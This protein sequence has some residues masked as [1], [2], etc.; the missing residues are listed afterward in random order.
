MTRD[1]SPTIE[2]RYGRAI[3][4]SHL[5][6]R[7]SAG[8]VDKLIAAGWIKD[9]MGPMLYRLQVEWDQVKS[10]HALALRHQAAWRDTAKRLREQ[11]K[12]LGDREPE[13]VARLHAQAA[14]VEKEADGAAV[15]E[16][17]L[18]LGKLRTLP[19]VKAAIGRWALQEASRFPLI[20]LGHRPPHAAVVRAAKECNLGPDHAVLELA[21]H[22]LRAHLDPLCRRCDG[23]GFSGGY[24]VP[25]V[26]C[27]VCRGSGRTRDALGRSD[28][29]RRFAQ[30]LLASLESQLGEVSHRLR[31]YRAGVAAG[32][33]AVLE[34]EAQARRQDG[35]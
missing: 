9:G 12:A 4:S 8:D 13:L 23:R 32:K 26:R 2:E 11:A 5:E 17:A 16:L 14:A 28:V 3:N 27:S 7:E 35:V 6:V 15:T 18:M 20:G 25:Q 24:G 1:A 34:A 33:R 22:V 19:Q 30:H 21:G 29:Q 10:E 31:S